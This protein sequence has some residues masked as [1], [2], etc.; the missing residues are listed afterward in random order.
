MYDK[1]KAWLSDDG[2]FYSSLFI[3]VAVSSFG[4]GR[5]SMLESAAVATPSQQTAAVVVSEALDSPELYYV[6][7]KNGTKY[8]L[9]WCPGASQMNEENKIRFET[10]ETAVAA[11]YTPAAN[12][13]GL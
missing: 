7:S 1:F 8:H 2:I 3:L 6:A 9:P 10:V 4:L 5:W 13:P 12:C 11:G